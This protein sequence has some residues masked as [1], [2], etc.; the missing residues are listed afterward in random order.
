MSDIMQPQ[1]LS[2]EELISVFEWIIERLKEN[3]SFEGSL[4]YTIDTADVSKFNLTA[5]IRYNNTMGQG[6]YRMI[7]KQPKE[8]KEEAVQ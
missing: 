8:E 4:T 6:M 7:G 1:I 2:K 3:D 5:F